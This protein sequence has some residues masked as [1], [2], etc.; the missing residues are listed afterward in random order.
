MI[1]PPRE[2]KRAPDCRSGRCGTALILV[3][4]VAS[5]AGFEQH[6][7]VTPPV[8]PTSQRLLGVGLIY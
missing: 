5:G 8:I 2:K 1:K 4:L 6:G 3:I 7:I